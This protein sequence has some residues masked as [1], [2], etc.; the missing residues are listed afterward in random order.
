MTQ[1]NKDAFLQIKN[2]QK[3][4]MEFSYWIVDGQYDSPFYNNI[5]INPGQ[6]W[7]DDSNAPRTIDEFIYYRPE[8]IGGYEGV[9]KV[10]HKTRYGA[11]YVVRIPGYQEVT[12]RQLN[13]TVNNDKGDVI[14]GN[15]KEVFMKE[16]E[17]KTSDF[18][19]LIW[20]LLILIVIA[21]TVYIMKR[22]E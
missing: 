12:G 19:I 17:K 2:N 20:I 16:A 7:T 13:I 8:G 3:Q 11:R 14:V 15:T 22:N 21:A 10:T 1:P 4:P 6:T 9:T 18:S 5:K